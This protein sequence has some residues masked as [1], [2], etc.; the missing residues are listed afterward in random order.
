MA[1]PG[2]HEPRNTVIVMKVGKV[3][4]AMSARPMK[5]ATQ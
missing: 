3:L 5:L 1:R 4:T 2:F